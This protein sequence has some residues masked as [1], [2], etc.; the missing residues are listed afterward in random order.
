ALYVPSAAGDPGYKELEAHG[1]TE[2]VMKEFPTAEID[3]FNTAAQQ[4]FEGKA[5]VNLDEKQREKYLSMIVD[6]KDISDAELRT[7]L[8]A[9]YRASRARILKVYYSNYPLNEVK[10]NAEGEAILHPGDVHQISNPNVW[11]DKKLVTG[12]DIAGFK[13]PLGWEEEEQLRAHAKKTI[14]YWF[15]EDLVKLNPS[16]PPPAT[17]VK[18]GEGHD[19]YDVI[20]LGGGTAGCII[21]GRLAERGINPKTGD[22]LKVA[23]IEGGDDWTIRDPG[24]RPGYGSPIRRRYISNI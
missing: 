24:I 16:R 4:F 12:W 6:G 14:D 20:V 13:G 22:R 17:A 3:G 5:F 8:Q 21:A 15:E 1:V 18:N 19:Y 11:K 23:M 9:F 10:R 2:Y 7:K